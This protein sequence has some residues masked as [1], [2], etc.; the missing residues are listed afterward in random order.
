MTATHAPLFTPYISEIIP[1][2]SRVRVL[3]FWNERNIYTP[4][5][6]VRDTG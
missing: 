3:V 4:V 1:E 5:I 6:R 2:M